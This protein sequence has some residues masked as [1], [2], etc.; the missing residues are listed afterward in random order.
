MLA[1]TLRLIKHDL[2]AT[3]LRLHKAKGFLTLS[4]SKI[5]YWFES[6][7]GAPAK[8]KGQAGGALISKGRDQKQLTFLAESKRVCIFIYIML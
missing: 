5:V 1:K 6:P 7:Y 2:Q 8:Q 4:S 3:G